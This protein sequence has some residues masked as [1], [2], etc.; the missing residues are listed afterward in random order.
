MMEPDYV[1][2]FAIVIS[3]RNAKF[4]SILCQKKGKKR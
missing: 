4:M 3:T 1:S 2:S